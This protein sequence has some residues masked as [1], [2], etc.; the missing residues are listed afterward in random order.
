MVSPILTVILTS[1][2]AGL[3]TAPIAAAHFNQIVHYGLIANILSVP[4]MGELVGP[5]AILSV[6]LMPFGAE[7]IGLWIVDIGLGWILKVATFFAN[8]ENAVSG[9]VM[10]ET[11]ILA[12][13]MVAVLQF[14][15]WLGRLR[16]LGA[17]GIFAAGLL[18]SQTQR[19]DILI[20]DRG[21]LVG[22]MTSEGRAMSK[23]K[24]A[25]FVAR[26]WRE[27]DGDKINQSDARERWKNQ[28]SPFFFQHW[29]KRNAAKTVH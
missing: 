3:A 25:G 27:N 21:A 20:A 13:G 17:F 15:L 29:S 11:W 26:I 9:I 6:S 5:G 7:L 12:L 23:P 4:V 2:I 28:R 19:P 16:I 24:G 22:V 10:P 14:S 1:L 18:W 8:Q